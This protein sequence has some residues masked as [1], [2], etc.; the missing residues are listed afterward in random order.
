MSERR[1]DGLKRALA[2]PFSKLRSFASPSPISGLLVR[3]DSVFQPT[4]SQGDYMN[5]RVLEREKISLE[6]RIRQLKENSG[7]T[8]IVKNEAQLRKHNENWRRFSLFSDEADTLN[9]ALATV[10]SSG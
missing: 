1:F 10:E 3:A 2:L 4:Y 8:L 6:T 7:T 5:L 9:E